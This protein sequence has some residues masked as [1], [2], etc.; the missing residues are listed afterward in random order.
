ME[1]NILPKCKKHIWLWE[2]TWHQLQERVRLDYEHFP[3]TSLILYFV[4]QF[5]YQHLLSVCFVFVPIVPGPWFV[6]TQTFFSLHCVVSPSPLSPSFVSW[7]SPPF[8]CGSPPP[9]SLPSP[10]SRTGSCPGECWA[11][12]R[13][14]RSQVKHSHLRHHSQTF[15]LETSQS[16][17]V[18][19]SKMF[20]MYSDMPCYF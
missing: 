4:F 1:A 3:Q 5:S 9:P 16:H 17:Q 10:C 14:Y 7:Q 18:T 11:D 12:C 19:T 8:P 20:L 6:S 2:C 15:T 13:P